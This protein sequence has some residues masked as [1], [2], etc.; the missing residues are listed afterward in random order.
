[1]K[2]TKDEPPRKNHV[3]V[4]DSFQSINLDQIND[5][6]SAIDG[7]PFSGVRRSHRQLIDSIRRKIHDDLKPP[8]MSNKS[9][10]LPT[11]LAVSVIRMYRRASDFTCFSDPT[12]LY[13]PPGQIIFD[14]D[15]DHQNNGELQ[16]TKI[17]KEE[18]NNSLSI[19]TE[20]SSLSNRLDNR[21]VNKRHL[22]RSYCFRSHK[23]QV[24]RDNESD[25]AKLSFTRRSRYSCQSDSLLS[26]NGMDSASSSELHSHPGNFRQRSYVLLTTDMPKH[27]RR[28]SFSAPN[29]L[30][31]QE[32]NK[33]E[34]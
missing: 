16:M 30:H 7:L 8:S 21:E 27:Q 29:I 28:R 33:S 3:I 4:R 26:S 20:V 6:K 24:R 2:I 12:G 18:T 31:K 17:H 15:T 9:A 34:A 1:M 11:H 5:E 14:S 32:M 22:A 10:S 19:M 13:P 25:D 23:G